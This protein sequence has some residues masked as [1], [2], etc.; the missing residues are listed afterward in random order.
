LSVKHKRMRFCVA[1]GFWP[2]QGEELVRE[3]QDQHIVY[4][5]VFKRRVSV[6][7]D[8]L[9]TLAALGAMNCFAEHRRAA[10]WRVEETLPDDL[11]GSACAAL[12]VSRASPD[13]HRK[14]FGRSTEKIWQGGRGP[15]APIAVSALVQRGCATM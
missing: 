6:S 7:K 11:L 10:M 8:E 4:L 15:L 2:E 1:N 9:R 5:D 14:L 13:T 3:R 12:A